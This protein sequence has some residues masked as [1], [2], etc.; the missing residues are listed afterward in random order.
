MNSGFVA[1]HLRMTNWP[2]TEIRDGVAAPRKAAVHC[3]RGYNV[4]ISSIFRDTTAS[5]RSNG[6]RD[7]EVAMNHNPPSLINNKRWLTVG[8][9]GKQNNH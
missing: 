4:T 9:A 6:W 1:S 7:E 8:K 3:R 5:R 2:T